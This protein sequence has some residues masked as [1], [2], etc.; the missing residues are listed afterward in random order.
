M[1]NL[2]VAV[3][4]GVARLNEKEPQ[5]PPDAYFIK[6]NERYLKNYIADSSKYHQLLKKSSPECIQRFSLFEVKP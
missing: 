4:Q 6:R 2:R 5:F 1:A 3:Q